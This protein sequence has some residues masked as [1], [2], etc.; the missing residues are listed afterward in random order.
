LITKVIQTDDL[1]V[2]EAMVVVMQRWRRY[3]SGG[4]ETTLWQ[5]DEY[6]QNSKL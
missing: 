6:E 2:V 5:L 3:A 4:D 1:M